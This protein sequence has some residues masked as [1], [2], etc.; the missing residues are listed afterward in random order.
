[1][2]LRWLEKNLLK[3][4]RLLK[5]TSLRRSL[6]KRSASATLSSRREPLL[7]NLMPKS[8]TSTVITMTYSAARRKSKKE[9]RSK[10]ES[11]PLDLLK[12]KSALRTVQRSKV[13][14]RKSKR[15]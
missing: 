2:T 15:L 8:T 3:T 4:K 14:L 1:V 7:D 12:E 9:S 10:L 6:K 5:N 11:S 13:F